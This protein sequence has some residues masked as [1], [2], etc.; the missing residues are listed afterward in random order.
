MQKSTIDNLQQL[1]P[2]ILVGK[3]PYPSPAYAQH[4][5]SIL[6]IL[7]DGEWH[8]AGEIAAE[9]GIGK[10]YV[11]DILRTCKDP[12]GLAVSNP[13]GWMLVKENSVIIL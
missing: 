1:A 6:R 7:D 9:L 3:L 8:T 2:D 13:K 11:R 12:W 10:K 4:A 5:I